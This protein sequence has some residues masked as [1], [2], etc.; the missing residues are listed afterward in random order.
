[1]LSPVLP[2]RLV[3]SRPSSR[4]NA[5]TSMLC[6]VNFQ[7]IRSPDES[8]PPVYPPGPRSLA[9]FAWIQLPMATAASRYSLIPVAAYS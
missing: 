6:S 5:N 8:Y 4:K 2:D 9:Q 3:V 1:M 7:V